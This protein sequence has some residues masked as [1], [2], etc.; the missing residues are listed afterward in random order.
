[1]NLAVKDT[2]VPGRR[3]SNPH[4]DAGP[5]H[6]PGFRPMGWSCSGVALCCRW[7]TVPGGARPRPDAPHRWWR[8]E[9]RWSDRHTRRRT[10]TE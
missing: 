9:R 10:R 1:M 4:L 3:E 6:G 7:A 5:P 8:V 2:G